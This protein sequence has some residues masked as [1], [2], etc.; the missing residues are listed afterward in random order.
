MSEYKHTRFKGKDYSTHQVVW[1][2]AN[3]DIPKGM[4]I[5]HKDHNRFNNELSN[6]ELLT[7]KQHVMHHH[8]KHLRVIKGKLHRACAK[9]GF[10]A[11]IE[12]WFY[13]SGLEKWICNPCYRLARRIYYHENAAHV[14]ER[15]RIRDERRMRN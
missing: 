10:V 11:P 14:K 12:E 6:L 1:M 15:E 3:G 7:T 9:C 5:H 2:K 8:G 4:V 13:P